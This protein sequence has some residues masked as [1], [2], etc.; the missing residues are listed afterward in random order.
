MVDWD[1]YHLFR[2]SDFLHILLLLNQQNSFILGLVAD[3]FCRDRPFNVSLLALNLSFSPDFSLS[4]TDYLYFNTV[5][6]GW[7]CSCL[8]LNQRCGQTHKLSHLLDLTPE[9]GAANSGP[10]VP[11]N[12]GHCC[13]HRPRNSSVIQ[14]QQVPPVR[15]IYLTQQIPADINRFNHK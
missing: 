4:I 7:C 6:V 5:P 2:L 11:V 14:L 1:F 10:I 9:P 8:P 13:P 15:H 12:S 3:E